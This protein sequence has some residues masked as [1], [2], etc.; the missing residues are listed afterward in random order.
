MPEMMA[1]S[2]A[3]SGGKNKGG[4]YVDRD[5]PAQIRFSNISAGKGI[6]PI[7]SSLVFFH[8]PDLNIISWVSCAP[9]SGML[10]PVCPGWA[11][12]KLTLTKTPFRNV[13]V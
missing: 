1:A 2:S 4:A 11:G 13:T 5:K 3:A 6:E 12:L 10:L 8:H 7:N 9:S